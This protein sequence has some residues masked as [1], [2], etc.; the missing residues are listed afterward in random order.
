MLGV[1]AVIDTNFRR[2]R[3]MEGIAIAKVRGVYKGRPAAIDA[4]GT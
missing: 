2:E 4:A 1:F 3:Q